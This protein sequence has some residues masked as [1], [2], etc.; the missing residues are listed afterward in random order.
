MKPLDISLDK[1]EGHTGTAVIALKFPFFKH[2][3][4]VRFGYIW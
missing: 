4:I 1:V 3:L 2:H